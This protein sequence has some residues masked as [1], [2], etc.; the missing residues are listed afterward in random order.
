MF[1]TINPA[2]GEVVQTYTYLSLKEIDSIVDKASSSFL[3]WREAA[4]PDRAEALRRLSVNF[5][6]HKQELASLM[7]QEMGKSLSEGIAEIEKCAFTCE[8]FAEKGGELLNPQ[9]IMENREVRFEP[10]GIIFSI[11]PWNFPFWQFIRFAAPSL[12]I[13]NVIL[14]KHA[15]ITAGCAGK[16]EKLCRNIWDE[17]IVFNLPIDH[18]EAMRL[19]HNPKIRGV[20]FTGSTRAG[21][22]VAKTAGEALKKTVLEL[23]GSDAYIIMSD[24]NIEKAAKICA[25]GRMINNGQSCIAAKRFIAHQDIFEDFVRQLKAELSAYPTSV[26]ASVDLQSQLQEQVEKMKALGAQVLLG[27]SILAG[28]GAYYPPTLLVFDKNDPEIHKEEL[29]GPVALVLKAESVEEAF[30]LANS[31]PFG[32]GGGIFSGNAEQAQELVAKKMEAGLVVVNDF[33]KSDPRLPF[34]GVKDSGFGRELGTFGFYEF[35]NVKTI[36]QGS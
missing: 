25:S 22:E 4:I 35:C 6:E 31:S 8:Y 33:V 14:L 5:R 17:Q 26:L 21:R 18:F 9:S 13:G 23:G 11:M 32:L 10:L 3:S 15:H 29:F 2:T 16:I 19:I 28:V 36:I 34:G 24:A 7:Q 20:T 1:Q 27:G 12:M 30:E